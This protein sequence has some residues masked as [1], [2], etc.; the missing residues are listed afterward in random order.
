MDSVVEAPTNFLRCE[1]DHTL[2]LVDRTVSVPVLPLT[3][4]PLIPHEVFDHLHLRHRLRGG[5]LDSR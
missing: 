5:G 2:H 3:D 1:D 4:A